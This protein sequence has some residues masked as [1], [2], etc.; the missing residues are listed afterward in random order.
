M[1]KSSCFNLDLIQTSDRLQSWLW[2]AQA[3]HMTHDPVQRRLSEGE[4][5]IVIAALSHLTH[6]DSNGVSF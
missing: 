1:I 6:H 4:E 3:T 5:M 2:H